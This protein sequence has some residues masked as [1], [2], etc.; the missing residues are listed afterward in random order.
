MVE[1]L[2][3]G[4]AAVSELAAPFDMALPSFM[5]HL[6]VLERSGLITSE[7]VGRTRTCRLA[8]RRFEQAEHWLARRREVWERSLDQ[9]DEYLS[10]M[11][12]DD[13]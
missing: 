3:R 12:D 1:R 8:A 11:E 4:P 6:K 5:Q 10:A 9:L 2:S 13:G 7:K